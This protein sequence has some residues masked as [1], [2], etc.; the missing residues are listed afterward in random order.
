MLGRATALGFLLSLSLLANAIQPWFTGPLLAPSTTTTPRGEFYLEQYETYTNNFKTYNNRWQATNTADFDVSAYAPILGVG[1]SDCV[2]ITINLSFA[3]N[4]SQGQQDSGLNDPQFILGYQALTQKDNSLTP[5]LR[6][7]YGQSVPVARYENLSSNKQ[8]TDSFGNGTFSNLISF[9]F[10]RLD[11]VSNDHY[12]ST[13]ASF[14]FSFP[15]RG[16]VLNL[17]AYGGTNGTD[18]V[19]TPGNTYAA[20]VAFEYQLTQNWVAVMEGNFSYTAKSNFEGTTGGVTVGNPATAQ[21]SF[22]PAVEYNFN[23]DWGVIFGCWF[24][25]TGRNTYD[26]ASAQLAINYNSVL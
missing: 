4:V 10:G 7:T 18:G 26:F 22:A 14:I 16:R 8:G 24:T 3:H 13:N 9:S 2:D 1:L 21:L 19:I 12:L 5:N 25:A 17:N 11:L 23:E 20:D 6:I 15:F